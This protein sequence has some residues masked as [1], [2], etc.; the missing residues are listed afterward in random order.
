M[1]LNRFDV[2]Q[3]INFDWKAEN[4]KDEVF[5]KTADFSSSTCKLRNLWTKKSEGT[6]K[7]A[8]KAE[9]PGHD[10]VM[11]RLTK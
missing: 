5:N 10:V 2:P 11:L 4:V 9:V 3:K 7:K 6:T 8:F 1:F